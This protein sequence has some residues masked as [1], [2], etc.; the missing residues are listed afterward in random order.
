MLLQ[1]YGAI[2]SADTTIANLMETS[3]LKFNFSFKDLGG[4]KADGTTAGGYAN[5][6]ILTGKVDVAFNNNPDLGTITINDLIR[7]LA[8]EMLH[9]YG[10]ILDPFNIFSDSMFEENL[11]D[12]YSKKICTELKITYDKQIAPA[13]DYQL[14]QEMYYGSGYPVLPS[15]FLCWF[16]PLIFVARDNYVKFLLAI[17]R[18]LFEHKKIE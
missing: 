15:S 1:A 5:I 11:G 7:N 9:C 2:R 12:I 14:L 4:W 16:N 8:H 3:A 18:G 6:N 17:F 13:N 10:H